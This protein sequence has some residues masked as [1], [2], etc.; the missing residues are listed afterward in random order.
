MSPEFQTGVNMSLKERIPIIPVTELEQPAFCR[1]DEPLVVKSLAEEFAAPVRWQTIPAEYLHLDGVAL[2][3]RIRLARDKLGDRVVILGHHYQREEIIQFA[4]VRGDSFKLSQY[5]ASSAS[6]EFIIFCGVHFMAETAEVLS[7]PHQKVILPN[8]TAGCSMSDM[9]ATDDV[10]DCWDD[11]EAILG[12][13]TVIPITYMNSTAAI[14]ALC[15]RNGGIVC[16][17]SNAPAIME[18]AFERGEKVLFLP[19]QHLGR[20]TAIKLGIPLGEMIT[21]NPFKPLG[22][23]TAEDIA[24]AKVILWQGHC[25]VHTRFTVQQIDKARDA[26]PDINVIVHPECTMDVVAS[27]DMDGSTEFIIKSITEAP[28]GSKWAVGTE[29]SLVNRLAKE[30]PDKLVYCLDSIVCPCSTMYRVHPA[31]LLWVMEGLLDNK[32]INEIPVDADISKHARVALER[33]LSVG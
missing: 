17:S 8:I 23:H 3:D 15:G 4:D 13:N 18:W 21:W 25:S 7:S 24:A 33:M 9:A 5:A 26:H 32:V 27:A 2:A 28:P 30:H 19:D 11:L 12:E 29:I 20:N 22:G 31:Y 14:K 1:D 6:A 10:V 16:T